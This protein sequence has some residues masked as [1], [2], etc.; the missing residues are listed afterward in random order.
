MVFCVPC[1]VP[2]QMITISYIIQKYNKEKCCFAIFTQKLPFKG[3]F[4]VF[5][6]LSISFWSNTSNISTF[7]MFRYKDEKDEDISNDGEENVEKRR[8]KTQKYDL[9]IWLF[10]LLL[11]HFF[12]VFFFPTFDILWASNAI[13]VFS[14]IEDIF[15]SVILCTF[16]F[17]LLIVENVFICFHFYKKKFVKNVKI[18]KAKLLWWCARV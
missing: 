11:F 13:V 16:R 1:R 6:P 18:F 17:P 4:N 5:F 14:H 15:L 3:L 10:N 9:S 12:F 7:Q 2:T 8:E